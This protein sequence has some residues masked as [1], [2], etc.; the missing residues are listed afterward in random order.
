M[1][2]SAAAIEP[3][4]EL[5]DVDPKLAARWLR[6]NVENRRVS[7][8]NVRNY[9]AAMKRGEWIFNGETVKFDTDGNLLDGQHR[10]LA[11]VESNL[12]VPIGVF[13]KLP[14]D[15]FKTIDIGKKRT[16]GDMLSMYGIKN[17]NAVAAAA[18]QIFFYGM[19]TWESKSSRWGAMT[20]TQMHETIDSHPDL[21]PTSERAMKEPLHTKMIPHSLNIFGY[22][23]TSR[24][25]MQLAS[26]FFTELASGRF[27]DDS[28]AVYTFRE[29]LIETNNE[30]DKPSPDVKLCWLIQCWNAF[31]Q[32]KDVARLARIYEAIPRFVPN[33]L[34]SQT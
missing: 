12:T 8:N 2:S 15:A 26:Q 1:T 27:A 33:P 25:D 10:L 24:V 4:F 5:V 28:D 31:Y 17:P 21:V 18:R 9:A 19:P 16:G 23:M 13:W 7:R 30:Y 3:K 22:Y 20:N 34:T 14:R 32:N 29:R 11:I 6:S